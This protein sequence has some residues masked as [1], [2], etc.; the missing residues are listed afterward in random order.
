MSYDNWFSS[1]LTALISAIEAQGNPSE[2]QPIVEEIQRGIKYVSE[3]PGSINPLLVRMGEG[4]IGPVIRTYKFG[5]T[6]NAKKTDIN[7]SELKQALG[8]REKNKVI[9]KMS[10]SLKA[11]EDFEG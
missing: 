5:A 8:N 11:L 7:I 9:N 6:D 3:N 1:N 2:I 4:L 10:G